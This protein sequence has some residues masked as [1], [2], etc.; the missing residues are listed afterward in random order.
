MS[1]GKVQLFRLGHNAGISAARNFAIA[2]STAALVACINCEV[3][4]APDWIRT[5]SSHL[6]QYPRVAGCFTRIV[7]Q[8]PR[9]LLSRWRMRFQEL[10][11]GDMRHSTFAPGHAVLF[12]REA[13][14]SVGGYDARFRRVRE[15]SEICERLK[16]R[17]G[18]RTTSPRAA[19]PPFRMMGFG[20]FR[21]KRWHAV[22]GIRQPTIHFREW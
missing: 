11:F 21:G 14:D 18:R 19:A 6:P 7:P 15:D 1:S 12:R 20:C 8:N 16:M 22:T 5:C 13:L 2:R 4:P 3:L 17:A 10:Q 9:R